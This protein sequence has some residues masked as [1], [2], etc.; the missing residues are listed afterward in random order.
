M[1]QIKGTV[2]L[3]KDSSYYACECVCNTPP[4]LS[5][6]FDCADRTMIDCNAWLKAWYSIH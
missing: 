1:T 6:L 5:S 3:S 4:P 2:I